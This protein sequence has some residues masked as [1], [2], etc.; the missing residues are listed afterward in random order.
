VTGPVGAEGVPRAIALT[1]ILG[2]RY[3]LEHLKAIRTAA[4]GATLIA[5]TADGHAERPLD[6]VEVVLCGRIAPRALDWMLARSPRLRWIHSVAAGVEHVLTPAVRSRGVVVT[7]ARG[8]FSRP[9]AEY[10]LLMILAVSRRLPELAALQAERTWQPLGGREMRELTIGVVG[11]G[12]IGRAVAELAATFGCRV[13]AT[14]RRGEPAPGETLPDGVTV[15]GPDRLADLLVAADFVVLAAPLTPE[16]DG[17]IGEDALDSM[18]RAAWLINV[19]R[20]R[21]VDEVALV[22]AIEEARIGGAVLDTFRDEPLPEDSPLWGLPNAIVTP[23]MSWSSG[24]VLGRSVEL[25]C[26]NLRRYATGEP[27]TNVVD[28]AAGY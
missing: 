26:D 27:L 13:I 5:V 12:S 3:R 8:V 17:L 23:C 4:P 2:A 15:L 19:A 7:N 18:K 16:T 21:L 14:R 28:A 9:V 24:A 10:V 25:F 20:G 1:P 6:E 22:R 11:F